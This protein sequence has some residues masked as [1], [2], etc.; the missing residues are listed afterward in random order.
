MAR[1]WCAVIRRASAWTPIT[2]ETQ[3]HA[4]AHLVAHAVTGTVPVWPQPASTRCGL[5]LPISM[6]VP[7]LGVVPVFMRSGAVLSVSMVG[8]IVMPQLQLRE[9]LPC[10]ICAQC[11]SSAVSRVST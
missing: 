4:R 2:T 9:D 10:R 11:C 8:F 3:L 6:G 5:A 1:A 7:S